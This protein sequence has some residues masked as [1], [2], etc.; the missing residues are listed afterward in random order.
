MWKIF[1]YV[2]VVS[3][4]FSPSNTPNVS[5]PPKAIAS[6]RKNTDLAIFRWVWSETNGFGAKAKIGFGCVCV[7]SFV[8]L[9][10]YVISLPASQPAIQPTGHPYTQPT[11]SFIPSSHH[12][13]KHPTNQPYIPPNQSTIQAFRVF[14]YTHTF[15]THIKINTHTHTDTHL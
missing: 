10:N 3:A 2:Y 11:I 13:S 14:E 15:L 6:S 12:P 7:G 9:S 8:Y 4:T 1:L 5:Q